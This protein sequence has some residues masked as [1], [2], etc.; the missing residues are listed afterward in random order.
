MKSIDFNPNIPKGQSVAQNRVMNLHWTAKLAS[1]TA[2]LYGTTNRPSDMSFFNCRK[3]WYLQR[4]SG[5]PGYNACTACGW[6]FIIFKKYHH[7]GKGVAENK[8]VN[9]CGPRC[10]TVVPPPSE[11]KRSPTIKVLKDTDPLVVSTCAQN[12]YNQGWGEFFFFFFRGSTSKGL[13]VK[14]GDILQHHFNTLTRPHV[15]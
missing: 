10:W 8:Y 4:E 7:A 15:S 9:L 5:L 1:S 2:V 14:Y 3:K 12:L 6:G 11:T 13:F